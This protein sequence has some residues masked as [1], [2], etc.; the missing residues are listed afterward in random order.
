MF[1]KKLQIDAK[2]LEQWNLIKEKK[3]KGCT[4]RQS[5]KFVLLNCLTKY[6]DINENSNFILDR[7][8]VLHQIV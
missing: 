3:V 4:F 8:N 5:L 6:L 2:C 7:K 1:L